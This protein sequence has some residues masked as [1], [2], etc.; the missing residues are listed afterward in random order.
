MPR[1]GNPSI[2]FNYSILPHSRLPKETGNLK[3]MDS[4]ST[5]ER[6]RLMAKVRSKG[7]RSTEVRV[8]MALIRSGI[9]GWTLHPR[10]VPGA[11]DFWFGSER[12][13]VFVDGCFWHG[14]R[15]CLRIPKQNREYWGAKIQG[16]I[17][18]ARQINRTLAKL[19]VRVIRIWEHDVR[20]D[21]SLA[22]AV[23]KVK[24]IARDGSR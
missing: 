4:L 13:A 15:R 19:G 12:L 2:Q 10:D 1:A 5:D 17:R 23:N 14:C 6:S 21:E 7:N 18:R 3:A 22:R 20:E 8:R 24:G 9:R 11:P 16:N